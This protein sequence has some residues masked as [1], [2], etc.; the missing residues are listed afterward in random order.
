MKNVKIIFILMNSNYSLILMKLATFLLNKINSYFLLVV[1]VLSFNNS[2]GQIISQYVETNSGT[3]PKGVEIWNNTG[4]TLDFSS[5]NLV[6]EKGNNGNSGIADVTVS[7][8][9][10]VSGAVMVIGSSDI[11]TYLTN[12]GL[13]GI[14][15]VTEGFT[16]NGDDA[17]IVKYGGT[18]TD[19]FGLEG[20]DPGSH[21]S[22]SSVSTRN[23]NIRL[24]DETD[25]A[26]S[27]I[28]SGDPDGWTDPS[29]RFVDDG[30]TP[31]AVDGLTGFGV[32]PI[33]TAWDGS[34]DT[35]WG[36]SANWSNGVPTATSN[37]SIPNVT[38][39]PI[40]ST[41]GVEVTNLTVKS[42]GAL[43]VNAGKD[44]TVSGNFSNS[45]TV[46]MNSDSANFSSLIVNGTSSGDI[47][48]N[49][50]VNNVSGWDLKGSPVGDG[51][52][53]G[54][55]TGSDFATTT[56]SSTAY[57][58]L[59]AYNNSNS[60]WTANSTSGSQ[61]LTPAKGYSTGT[62]S[63]GTVLFTGPLDDDNVTI[64]ITESVSGSGDQ[65]NLV[66]NPYPSYLALN[67]LAS[68]ASDARAF[69]AR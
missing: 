25:S 7:S 62:T 12:Q 17:L 43:T 47:R 19:M 40:I 22:G 36:T 54:S 23:S 11:G 39:D 58:A 33:T 49:L 68:D 26:G 5:N 32:A 38:N 24:I 31:N 1:V 57:Y 52:S 67:A 66:A 63:G 59:Q 44:L 64:A 34:A 53:N 48:Y 16:F 35:A 42:S 4:S 65:W 6:I 30:Y 20:E 37:V 13:T 61:T 69:N 14:T 29:S 45:G 15:F 27:G 55:V 56:I 9:T 3:T 50:Y 8:G 46:T 60:S 28:S 18:T 41:T 10:L 51:S 21:W 2:F